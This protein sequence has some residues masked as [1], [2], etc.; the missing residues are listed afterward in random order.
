MFRQTHL[1]T[2]I[3]LDAYFGS[4]IRNLTGH[5]EMGTVITFSSPTL[6]QIDDPTITRNC[7]TAAWQ[8]R[9]LLSSSDATG[10]HFHLGMAL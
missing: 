7:F 4:C 10:E 6:L 9:T 2:T 1:P 5:L 8:K 3:T